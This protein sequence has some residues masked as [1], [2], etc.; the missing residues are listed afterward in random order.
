MCFKNFHLCFRQN[1]RTKN[2]CLYISLRLYSKLHLS[3][4][5]KRRTKKKWDQ[6]WGRLNKEGNIWWRG[7]AYDE[8]VDVMGSS[9]MG[10]IREL[11]FL[12][13]PL[14][15]SLRV[16]SDHDDMPH[17][18]LHAHVIWWRP[19][20]HYALGPYFF[21]AHII[22]LFFLVPTIRRGGSNGL[23]YPVNPRFDFEGRW[24]KR[25]EWPEALQY[26]WQL[27]DTP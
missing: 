16:W 26:N 27:D 24:R 11:Y 5:A 7:N 12:S 9:W 10:W 25:S 13:I 8:W 23:E 18:L 19:I 21:V 17:S 15:C 6:E 2:H 22:F 3:C 20:R 14:S 1:Q 4:S